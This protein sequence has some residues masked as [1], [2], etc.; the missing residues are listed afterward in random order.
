MK[1]LDRLVHRDLPAT[2]RVTQT[3]RV[4]RDPLETNRVVPEALRALTAADP[5]QTAVLLLSDLNKNQYYLNS[6]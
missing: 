2:D 6:I 1:T 4:L 3:V 5:D